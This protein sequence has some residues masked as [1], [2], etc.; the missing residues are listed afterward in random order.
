MKNQ[1]QIIVTGED[2]E[3][4]I[5]VSPFRTAQEIRDFK[6]LL[7]E[8]RYTA[9]VIPPG[10]IKSPITALQWLESS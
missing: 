6:S 7:D 4:P 10:S 5:L 3:N 2:I 1:Y 9:Y 8:D